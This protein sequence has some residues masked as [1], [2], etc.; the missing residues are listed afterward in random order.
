MMLINTVSLSPFPKV[1]LSWFICPSTIWLLFAALSFTI[2]R[3]DLPP[4]LA[5]SST[6]NISHLSEYFPPDSALVVLDD[7]GTNSFEEGG[8]MQEHPLSPD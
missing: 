6:F 7:S 8:P 3:L 1:V 4:N 5:I 2:A